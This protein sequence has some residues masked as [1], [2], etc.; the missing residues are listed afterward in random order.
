MSKYKRTQGPNGEEMIEVTGQ[1]NR[2]EPR[3]RLDN[4][5]FVYFE[6]VQSA[7]MQRRA[8]KIRN[9]KKRKQLDRQVAMPWSSESMQVKGGE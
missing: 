2:K 7:C 8:A 5:P 3:T 9:K 1:T 4:I 6:Y